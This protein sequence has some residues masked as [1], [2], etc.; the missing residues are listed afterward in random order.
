[1]YKYKVWVNLPKEN[2]TIHTIIWADHDYDA[3]LIAEAQF[4]VGN[5]WGYSRV[6]E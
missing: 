4:G 5:V 1:M 2:R 3:K 6:D